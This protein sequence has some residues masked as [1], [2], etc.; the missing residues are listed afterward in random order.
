MAKHQVTLFEI[1]GFAVKV[2]W[3]WAILAMLI[4]WS[5]AQGFFPSLYE[6]LPTAAYWWMGVAGV[7]GLFLSI[8]LHELS[9]SVVARYYGLPIRGITLF[10]FG[11]VAELEEEP[12]SPRI[13][14]RM[15]I[16]GPLLSVALAGLFYLAVLLGQALGWAEAV[17]G[18][19]R[20]LATLNLI[21]AVFNLIPA[22]P[23]DGG[24]VLRAYLWHRWR[25]MRRAT[26]VAANAGIG[27][28]VVLMGIGILSVVS[29]DLG[30]GI[31][32]ILIGLFLRNAAMGSYY[33][34]R[35]RQ[36]IKGRTVRDFMSGSPIAVSPYLSIRQLAEDFVLRHH[37]EFFPV[38]EAGRILGA[39]SM[40]EIKDLPRDRW[41]STRVGDLMIGVSDA[42]M[43]EARTDAMAA[44]LLMQKRGASRL[45]VIDGGIL[46]G[47]LS[48][49]DL[50]KQLSLQLEIEDAAE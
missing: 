20:Y 4:A 32:W 49:K 39:I 21:L 6:G 41:D 50:L 35:T 1:A 18:V 11:G 19:A 9:H 37:H 14:F 34:L 30:T 31:W 33:D 38:V 8:L 36:A 46:V 45:M 42:N 40:R 25:D 48:L 3:S 2:D 10:I 5:L 44:L 13:E 17:V 7:I 22:F 26:R 43:V 28:S 27:F 15:A 23:L 47:I 29:G 16:A 12:L 24:R